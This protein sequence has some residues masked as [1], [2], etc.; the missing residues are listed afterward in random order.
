MKILVASRHEKNL[1][2]CG[3]FSV[4]ILRCFYTTNTQI[5]YSQIL[6]HWRPTLIPRY[7]HVVWIFRFSFTVICFGFGFQKLQKFCT[8]M[9]ST[10]CCPSLFAQRR[11]T[12]KS[13]GSTWM[14]CTSCHGPLHIYRP[15]GYL[16]YSISYPLYV[17][18]KQTLNYWI[19]Q[20]RCSIVGIILLWIIWKEMRWRKFYAN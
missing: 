13:A 15:G 12:R 19:S 11:R 6:C 16:A 18:T 5:N 14:N 2:N 10:R 9:T 8:S 1:C 3:S 17:W 7:M 20:V 4:W